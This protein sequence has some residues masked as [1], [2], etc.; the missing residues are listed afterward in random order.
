VCLKCLRVLGRSRSCCLNQ[1]PP[2][3]ENNCTSTGI[4]LRFKKVEKEDGPKDCSNFLF[5]IFISLDLVEDCSIAGYEEEEYGDTRLPYGHNY[6]SNFCCYLY[7]PGPGGGLQYSGLQ[8]GVRG[9]HEAALRS[10][11]LL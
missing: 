9:K 8:G 11:Q 10:Q 5:V 3:V 6:W 4:C 1:V 2:Y 7:W